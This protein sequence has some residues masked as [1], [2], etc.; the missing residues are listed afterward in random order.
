MDRGL[1]GLAR[2]NGVN[3]ATFV[4]SKPRSR[5]SGAR[6]AGLGAPMS[7]REF[8]KANERWCVREMD[9]R[10]V[11]G[12]R[13]DRCLICESTD[14]IR[15]LWEYPANWEELDDEA[16]WTLCHADA[17]LRSARARDPGGPPN[18]A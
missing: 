9:T 12:A 11:P 18:V 1:L 7:I 3:R 5:I 2:E 17:H 6:C 10:T 8:E 13:A 4:E 14:V 16:L 15:R